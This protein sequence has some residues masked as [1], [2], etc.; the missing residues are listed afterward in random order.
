M[1]SRD[2]HDRTEAWVK[3][4]DQRLGDFETEEPLTEEMVTTQRDIY[5]QQLWGDYQTA[6]KAITT[7]YKG[8]K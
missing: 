8:K 4:G 5:V 3:E 6:A 1:T 2:N 7:L